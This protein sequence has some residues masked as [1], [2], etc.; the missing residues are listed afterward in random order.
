[1]IDMTKERILLLNDLKCRLYTETKCL[2]IWADV[3]KNGSEGAINELDTY[4]LDEL[5]M[6]D[7][8]DCE[9]MFSDI[10]PY[11]RSMESMTDE[12][13]DIYD[14]MVMCNAPWVVVDWLNK[15]HLDYL[16]LIKLGLALEAPE[17]M[18]KF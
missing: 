8:P 1:L 4:I 7:D 13:K 3:A 11:L 9:H 17:G 6:I 10:K 2:C 15:H 16:G 14:M 12:E 5:E 18:Y